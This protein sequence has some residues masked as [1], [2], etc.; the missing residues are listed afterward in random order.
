MKY[1]IKHPKPKTKGFNN[2]N[3]IPENIRNVNRPKNNINKAIPG[4][5]NI[6]I[7]I[8]IKPSNSNIFTHFLCLLVPLCFL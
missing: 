2:I 5:A 3:P 1:K 7:I 6:N 8:K 4:F